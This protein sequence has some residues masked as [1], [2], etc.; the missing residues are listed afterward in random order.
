MSS[1]CVC[2]HRLKANLSANSSL[3]ALM[4]G[5]FIKDMYR[6]THVRKYCA[7]VHRSDAELFEFI[8]IGRMHHKYETMI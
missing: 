1:V 7:S 5:K 4:S 8:F 3:F 2:Y 6:M